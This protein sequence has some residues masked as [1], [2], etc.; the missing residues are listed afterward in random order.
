LVILTED[1]VCPNG[2]PRP[3]L[4]GIEEVAYATQPT[5]R[6]P[7][8]SEAS[9]LTGAIPVAGVTGGYGSPAAVPSPIE[10]ESSFTSGYAMGQ[11]PAFAGPS[12]DAIPLDNPWQ[13]GVNTYGIDPELQA[14]LDRDMARAR[15]EVPWTESWAAI[16]IFLIFFWPVGIVFLWRSSVP[17]TSVKWGITGVFAA[18]VTFNVIRFMLSYQVAMSAMQA[19]P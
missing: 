9:V 7:R 14:Q 12:G 1:G 19:Q 16:I 11:P 2:H 10:A 18:L 8:A 6:A 17:A 5:E 4:Q 3:A 13:A 15:R